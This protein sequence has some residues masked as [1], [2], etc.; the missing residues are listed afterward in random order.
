MTLPQWFAL[1][2]AGGT[3]AAARATIIPDSQ[4]RDFDDGSPI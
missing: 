4:R 3:L 1:D 2:G